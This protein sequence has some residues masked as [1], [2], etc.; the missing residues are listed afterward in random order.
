MI[1]TD[2]LT[3]FG[4]GFAFITAVAIVL[5][6]LG[7]VVMALWLAVSSIRI[8]LEEWTVSPEEHRRDAAI[9]R[10][11]R[12][13]TARLARLERRSRPVVELLH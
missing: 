10:L 9:A 4:L 3:G 1:A 8:L 7:G 6:A 13:T 2:L 11:E 12:A 5:L